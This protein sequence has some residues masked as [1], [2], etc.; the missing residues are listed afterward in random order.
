MH[1]K[2]KKKRLILYVLFCNPRQKE[3]NGRNILSWEK[4]SPE[5]LLTSQN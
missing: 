2:K 4:D 1:L 3:L 5:T